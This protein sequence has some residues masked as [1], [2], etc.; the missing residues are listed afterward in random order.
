MSNAMLCVEIGLNSAK[1]VLLR[2][3][4]TRASPSTMMKKS[5]PFSPCVVMAL[6][7]S[8]CTA[9][10]AS[11]TVSRSHWSRFSRMDTLDRNSSYIFLFLMVE[12]IRMRL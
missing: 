6:P 8:N 7:A 2:T 5:S 9:S 1:K 11:A 4:V 10:S 12:P 3:C